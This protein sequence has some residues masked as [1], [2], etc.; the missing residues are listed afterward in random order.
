M[1]PEIILPPRPIETKPIENT[2]KPAE[3]IVKPIENTAKPKPTENK[4]RSTSPL[5]GH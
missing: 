4:T 5:T 1:Q 2:A 3:S